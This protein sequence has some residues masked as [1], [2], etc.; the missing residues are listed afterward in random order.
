MKAAEMATAHLPK[1]PKAD[2]DDDENK[3]FSPSQAGRV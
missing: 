3:P 1:P 2:K